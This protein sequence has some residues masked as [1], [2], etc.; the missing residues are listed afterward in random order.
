LRFLLSFIREKGE[1]HV[2]IIAA[3]DHGLLKPTVSLDRLILSSVKPL[4]NQDVLGQ[5]DV[6]QPFCSFSYE[7]G[8]RLYAWKVDL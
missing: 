3:P 1:D 8:N 7:A 5:L 6:G 4:E 2:F